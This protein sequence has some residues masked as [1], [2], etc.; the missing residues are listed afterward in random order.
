MSAEATTVAETDDECGRRHR[1]SSKMF[2]GQGPRRSSRCRTSTSTVAPGEFVSLIGP[3]GCGKCTLLRLIA[4]LDRADR[5]APSRSSASPPRRPASTRT[6]AS[7]SSRPGCCRGAPCAANIELPLELHGIGQA[8][9]RGP[10]PRELLEL[11]GLADFAAHR[12]DQLSGGMQQRVAIA[13]ALAEQPAAAADGRAVRRARRDDPRAHAGRAGADLRRDRRGRRVR[14]PLDPGGGVPVRPGRRDVGRGPGRITEI[15]DVELGDRT[16]DLREQDGRSSTRSPRCA[17][18]C[19]VRTP[20]RRRPRGGPAM[21]GSP[22]MRAVSSPRRWWSGCCSCC[23]GSCS[24][25]CRNI[26]PYVL[27]SPIGDLGR[28]CSRLRERHL[29]GMPRTAARTPWS[30]C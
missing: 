30:G 18:R 15:V 6:T 28:S 8:A 5:R 23:C 26:A 22:R 13:R 1:A 14:H 29:G 4:D 3:S 19:A 17:R 10:G 11:V 25:S 21:S 2:A 7:R 12:P 20:P 16:E 24:S 27:P 9:A